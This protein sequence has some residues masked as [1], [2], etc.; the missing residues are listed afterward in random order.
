M[1]Y[2][3]LASVQL[4]ATLWTVARQAPLSVGFSRRILEWIA[5]PSSRRSSQVSYVSFTSRWV[6]TDTHKKIV[7]KSAIVLFFWPCQTACG[8]LVPWP[9]FE[10]LPPALEAWSA[11]EVPTVSYELKKWGWDLKMMRN[12]LK[13][14]DQEED[15]ASGVHSMSCW[16]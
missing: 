2:A 13:A 4:F 15:K 6:H 8:I 11:R 5:V 1:L 14:I 12:G 16:T 10:P 9:G 7:H 3:T